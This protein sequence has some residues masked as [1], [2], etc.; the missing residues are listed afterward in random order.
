MSDSLPVRRYRLRAGVAPDFETFLVPGEAYA[1]QVVQSSPR[2][3]PPLVRLFHPTDNA[4]WEDVPML[5]LD[6]VGEP[7][8]A[9]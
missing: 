4:L 3:D 5:A 8:A 2:R 1:G 9:G 7:P 6:E